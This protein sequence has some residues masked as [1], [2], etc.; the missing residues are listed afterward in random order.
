[1]GKVFIATR[2]ILISLIT[3][4]L[5]AIAY[6]IILY[7][8][9]IKIDLKNRRLEKTGMLFIK[10]DPSDSTVRI[11]GKIVGEETP[12]KVRWL[13]PGQYQVKVC[14]DG[15]QCW[16]K[17]V[18]IK[19][20]LVKEEKSI[21]L[22]LINPEQRLVARAQKTTFL[23]NKQ[24]GYLFNKK[25]IIFFSLSPDRKRPV[26]VLKEDIKQVQVNTN[27]TKALINQK[28]VIDL[29]SGKTLV[30][31]K[32]Q[33]P[34]YRNFN[35]P[36]DDPNLLISQFKN[37]LYL[38][39]LRTKKADKFWRIDPKISYRWDRDG[40]WFLN[41]K[42]K[43][44]RLYLI[45]WSGRRRMITQG[46]IE[47]KIEENNKSL[48]LADLKLVKRS[49]KVLLQDDEG[50]F[51]QVQ[52]NR[53]IYLGSA[54]SDLKFD[55]R[56]ESRYLFATDQGEIWLNT[57]PEKSSD[58][59]KRL[60]TRLTNQPSNLNFLGYGYLT[61]LAVGSLKI[62]DYC[63]SNNIVILPNTKISKYWVLDE[64]NILIFTDDQRLIKVTIS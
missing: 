45:D 36:A 27:Q 61:Y 13:F 41:K 5:L 10:A 59:E 49:E 29:L 26:A 14:K 6:Y 38:I 30:D 7:S 20:G 44:A 53:L 16:Q 42:K 25:K 9:G 52:N 51:F 32:R 60:V 54:V 62:C 22:F 35:F 50:H 4:S 11:D 8:L 40:I 43:P 55:T 23:E 56:T 2:W 17:A 24:G 64:K 12:L 33:F 31:L 19:P 21:R 1:M 57:P 34:G 37:N 63:G 58:K 3:V 15:Y 46:E 47:T 18:E 39:D 48:E 28:L